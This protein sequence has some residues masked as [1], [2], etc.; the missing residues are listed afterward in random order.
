MTNDTLKSLGY[1]R[2]SIKMS[3]RAININKV[4]DAVAIQ[5][6]TEMEQGMDGLLA[7]IEKWENLYIN[8]PKVNPT[9]SDSGS[10]S[11]PNFT[12]DGTDDSDLLTNL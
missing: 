3:K 7:Q 6:F 4:D 2:R 9:G 12:S 11:V 8:A 10:G 1:L 5:E